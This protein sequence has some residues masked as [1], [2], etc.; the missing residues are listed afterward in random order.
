MHFCSVHTKK[1]WSGSWLTSGMALHLVAWTSA[2][3]GGRLAWCTVKPATY[4]YWVQDSLRR[5]CALENLSTSAPFLGG[6]IGSDQRCVIVALEL[7]NGTVWRGCWGCS[8]WFMKI[9]AKFILNCLP[10][11]GCDGWWNDALVVVRTELE[12]IVCENILKLKQHFLKTGSSEVYNAT[13][14][15]TATSLFNNMKNTS[16]CQ[17]WD[18]I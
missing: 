16:C 11:I 2:D 15:K 8:Y 9:Y 17:N 5:R 13:L 12:A 7:S 6:E 10:S 18:N 1:L 4:C 14:L 3:A